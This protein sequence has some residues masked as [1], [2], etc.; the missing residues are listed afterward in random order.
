MKEVTCLNLIESIKKLRSLKKLSF[1]RNHSSTA[2]IKQ[3]AT[4]AQ[5]LNLTA[6]SLSHCNVTDESLRVLNQNLSS[7]TIEELDL[8]WNHLTN[9]SCKEMKALLIDMTS[10]TT[11]CIQHNELGG[12]SF[13][14]LAKALDDHDKLEYLDISFNKL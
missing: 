2:V 10:L 7:K 9:D 3:L 8:S 5:Y 1:N 14:G 13:Q 11:L 12:T 6:L 4:V